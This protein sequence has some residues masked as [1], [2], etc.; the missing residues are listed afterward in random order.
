MKHEIYQDGKIKLTLQST[1]GSACDIV[2]MPKTLVK[3]CS[4][5]AKGFEELFFCFLDQNVT[6]TEAYE[7]AE[8]VHESFFEKRKY[9]GFESFKQVQYRNHNKK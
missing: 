5:S 7:K 6:H 3:E 2:V 1:D 9:S 8:T 4:M